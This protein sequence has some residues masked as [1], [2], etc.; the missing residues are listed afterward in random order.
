ME[1]EK[2]V[3]AHPGTAF[4]SAVTTVQAFAI[5]ADVLDRRNVGRRRF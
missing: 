4:C 5:V 2:L 1:T 3:A